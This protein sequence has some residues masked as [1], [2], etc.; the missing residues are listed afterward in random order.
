MSH[1]L[2]QLKRHTVVVADTGD[3]LQLAQFAPRD[4][5]TN[6]SLILKA[7]QMPEYA[8]VVDKAIADARQAASGSALLGAAMDQIAVAFGL[9]I[10]KIVPNR[11]STEVDA[12]LSFD[13]AMDQKYAAA[14]DKAI[15]D[16]KKAIEIDP[17]FEAAKE[18][19][20][21]VTAGKK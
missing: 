6:P 11:V 14:V 16:Y 9:E 12:R 3:F 15:A 10:L 1:T 18:G 2:E 13:A 4:A 7:A 19:L 17:E 21:E 8:A 5:T 20:N